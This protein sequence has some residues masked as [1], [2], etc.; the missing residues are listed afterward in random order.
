MSNF[1]SAEPET[2]SASVLAIIFA[3]NGDVDLNESD[4]FDTCYLKEDPDEIARFRDSR[5]TE[6]EGLASNGVFT[7]I[8]RSE[9]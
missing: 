2:I 7:V 4:V 8:P 1:F 3:E 9:V 5:K 6:L